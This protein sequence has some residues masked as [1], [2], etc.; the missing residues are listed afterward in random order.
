MGDL[1]KHLVSLQVVSEDGF[2]DNA[3][4]RPIT[5]GF[6]DAEFDPFSLG[7]H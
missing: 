6:V 2:P 7:R 3:I 1:H 5:D 4:E